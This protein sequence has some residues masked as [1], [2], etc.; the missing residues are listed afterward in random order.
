MPQEVQGKNRK[1]ALPYHG[2]YRILKVQANC[3]LVRPVDKQSMQAILVSMDRVTQCPKELPNTSYL[4][5]RQK[6]MKN[7]KPHL[8]TTATLPQKITHSYGLH[9][10][11]KINVDV[12]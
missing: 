6:R 12:D 1:F 8:S 9:S 7:R 4:G 5:P 3:L 10:K 2:P 11:A